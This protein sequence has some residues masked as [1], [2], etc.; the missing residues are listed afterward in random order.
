MS[1]LTKTAALVPGYLDTVLR[2]EGF[3]GNIPKSLTS[4]K[5]I[6]NE[7]EF[8]VDYCLFVLQLRNGT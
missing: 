8:N 4:Y 2:T 6:A 7:L 1:H 3:E 5:E